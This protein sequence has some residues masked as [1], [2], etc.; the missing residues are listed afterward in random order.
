MG[1]Q[2]GM[3]TPSSDNRPEVVGVPAAARLLGVSPQA[4]RGHLRSGA[5]K[6]SKRRGTFGE[7][8]YFRPAVL[9]AFAAEHYGRTID[10]EALDRATASKPQQPTEPASEALLDVYERLIVACEEA[11]RYRA[12]CEVA[13]STKAE[14]QA[15]F[16]A[17]VARLTQ[18][19]DAALAE[20]ER[21]RELE[22]ERE[23]ARARG[24]WRR[25]F[26]KG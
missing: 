13:E 22:A 18:E 5:L 25:H 14:A 20:L 7:T 17:D 1:E 8:W 6:A 11:A 16:A 9:A 19:R 26:T 15:A 24:F 2:G 10:E 21:L 23:R 12:L 4:V 3:G